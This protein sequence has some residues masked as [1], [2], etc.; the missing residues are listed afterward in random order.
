MEDYHHLTAPALYASAHGRKCE[1]PDR[2][3]WC[4]APCPRLLIHDDNRSPMIQTRHPHARF[5]GNAY[6]CMG[7][8]LFGRQRVT[9]FYADGT[10]KDGQTPY[11]HS[12]WITEKECRSIRI[13]Q[14]APS[15]YRMI[16]RPPLKFAL[17][18]LDGPNPPPNRL[19]LALANDHQEIKASTP[20][21]FTVNEVPFCYNIYELEEVL[22]SPDADLSGRLP[23][24][25]EL[26]RLLGP[27]KELEDSI[28]K[29]RGRPSGSET[30]PNMTKKLVAATATSGFPTVPELRLKNDKST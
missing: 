15:L 26:I 9:V 24:V 19:Q 20:L 3:H 6:Q 13:P 29:E 23:G 28:K 1:G 7:C 30:L 22:T 18:L 21:T 16:L 17:A 4:G 8:W 25:R 2:C 27:Y 14:D 5:P 12:W 10:Y 11:K